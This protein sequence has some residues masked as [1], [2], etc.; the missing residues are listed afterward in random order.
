[1]RI[2]TGFAFAVVAPSLFWVGVLA[3]S[4]MSGLLALAPAPAFA[5]LM[6]FG[7][8]DGGPGDG[9]GIVNGVVVIVGHA[10]GNATVS[11]TGK[12]FS[13]GL[14]YDQLRVTD[15]TITAGPLG[16]N[17]PLI[18][19]IED[20]YSLPQGS[21]HNEVNLVGSFVSFAPGG[22]PAGQQVGARNFGSTFS[23]DTIDVTYTTPNTGLGVNAF[24]EFRTVVQRI[25]G[26]RGRIWELW[27]GN[28]RR[29]RL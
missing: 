6:L 14:T 1:M 28:L 11:G 9:D 21:G 25:A 27:L 15:M 2:K 10:V 19:A 17:S 12:H 29:L 3:V 7:V 8:Q 4:A 24:S 18:V 16:D 23:P 26:E 20:L 22:V 5:T 13:D